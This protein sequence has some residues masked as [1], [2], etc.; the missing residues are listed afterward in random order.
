MS[1]RRVKSSAKRSQTSLVLPIAQ[2]IGELEKAKQ[3][4]V[5]MKSKIRS[6][7]LLISRRPTFLFLSP[8]NV[9]RCEIIFI[10]D[11]WMDKSIDRYMS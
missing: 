5:A 2:Q 10:E 11:G 1:V 4:G 7:R 8:R 6:V 3:E 9:G